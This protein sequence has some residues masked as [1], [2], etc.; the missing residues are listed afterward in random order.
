MPQAVKSKA[1][2]APVLIRE[3]EAA[4]KRFNMYP[5]G[6]PA[7]KTAAQV[8]Y[9]TLKQAFEESKLVVI[10]LVE[11]NLAVNGKPLEG[12]QGKIVLKEALTHLNLHSI[13]FSTDIDEESFQKFLV[14]FIGKTGGKIDWNDLEEY[15]RE[16]SINGMA[17]D[18][19]RYEL[20]GK[21]QTVVN[22]NAMVI[23]GGGGSGGAG[24]SGG[25][26]VPISKLFEEHPDLILGLL[27]N[28]DSARS[29]ISEEYASAIDF[30]KLA[31]NLEEEMGEIS[32]DQLLTIIAAG[33]KNNVSEAGDYDEVDIQETLYK[34]TDMLE[35]RN[36]AEMV[37]RIKKIA[38]QLHLI[39]DRYIDLILDKKYSRK[40]L[41]LDELE[42]AREDFESGKLDSGRIAMAAKRLE[43]YDDKDYT[44]AFVKDLTDRVNSDSDDWQKVG[45]AFGKMVET[46]AES[47]GEKTLE[48][49][50][51]RILDNLR[52]YDLN[53][54]RFVYYLEQAEKLVGWLSDKENLPKL[55]ELF[56][57]ISVFTSKELMTSVEKREAARDFY[58]RIGTNELTGKLIKSL[59][60]NFEELNRLTFD[61]LKQVPVQAVV[62][63]ICE[64]LS[65]HDRSIRLFTIRVLS[66]YEVMSPRAF[67][68]IISDKKLKDRP[69]GQNLLEQEKWYKLRNII[70]VC[71]NIASPESIQILEGF[72]SDP[73]PRIAEEMILALEKIRSEKTVAMLTSYLYHNDSKIRLRA[74]VALG[75]I[76][77]ETCLGKLIDAFR[78]ETEVRS[79]MIPVIA[80]L[81]QE[82]ALPF[83]RQ[84]LFEQK[85]SI[86]KS[87]LGKSSDD[88]K[89]Q[90]L[91]ALAKIPSTKTLQLLDDFK[92]SLNKGLGS[93]FKSNKV[94]V[95]LENTKRS[96]SS[97][98]E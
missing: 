14:Y 81:G 13:S 77:D 58:E 11:G 3:I 33:L 15:I 54:E 36:Q 28:K 45:E 26:G 7:S 53:E 49:L 59:E 70:L 5:A 92:T 74:A 38:E 97:K 86:L 44:V 35:K 2:F 25:G 76:G 19:L 10:G 1:D 34:I 80:R 90:I 4:I 43:I 48:E 23:G 41:A 42:K 17:V 29:G 18:E 46:A 66:E 60:N 39:D 82:K 51:L 65:Y 9:N 8:P 22:G 96:I 32:D 31:G 61:V 95:A 27:A 75:T 69:P 88:F 78:Q 93:L 72:V 83:F 71:G 84:I 67:Q 91:S 47:R 24:G 73:D 62:L 98:L 63:K 64:Y 12:L 55:K 50:Y 6:H 30:S 37:P 94:L 16:N 79:Q 68:L 21:D 85:E 89:L 20:V 52:N 40:K 87:F 56:D 57:I